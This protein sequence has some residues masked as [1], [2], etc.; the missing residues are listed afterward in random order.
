M[1]W[2]VKFSLDAARRA[3]PSPDGEDD[4]QCEIDPADLAASEGREH[5]HDR[6]NHVAA[7]REMIGA[8]RAKLAAPIATDRLEPQTELWD[9][10]KETLA[11]YVFGPSPGTAGIAT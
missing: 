3:T 10:V 2:K 9:A 6:G 4:R 1:F 11:V 5:D 8:S 7:A